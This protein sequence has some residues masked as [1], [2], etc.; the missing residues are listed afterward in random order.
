MFWVTDPR[1]LIGI[2]GTDFIIFIYGLYWTIYY[3]EHVR[4]VKIKKYQTFKL[5]ETV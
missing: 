2:R 3:M 5:V 4:Y 1:R